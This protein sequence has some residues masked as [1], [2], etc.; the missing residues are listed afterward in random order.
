MALQDLTP[1]LRTRLS[2]MERA[3]GWFVILA[4]AVLSFGFVYYVYATAERK[5][6]F[7]LKAPYYT[8][9]ERAT[10]LKV[11]DP[12]ELMG[13]D[14]G[15]ITRIDAQKPWD[16]NNVYVEFEI[17]QPYYGYLWS[18][19]SRTKVNTAD[20]LGKRVL[21]V[22]KGTGGYSTYTFHP[23]REVSLAEA[24]DYA[25]SPNWRLAQE[26]LENRT[27]I[28]ARPRWPLTNLAAFTAA[29]YS[30]LT[31]MN[32]NETRKALAGI[33]NPWRGR[34]EIYTNGVSKYWLVADESAAVTERLEKLVGQIEAA[35]P[36]ILN[37]T[38]QLG[39]TLANGAN[40]T[41]NLNEVAVSLR[42]AVSNLAAATA[43]LDQPGALGVW[44]LP[45]NIHSNLEGVVSGANTNLAALAENLSR[46]L[47]NLAD[48]TSNLN[49]QV[50]ANTNLL[51]T[52][53][54]TI[55]DADQFVQGLKRH[56]LLRSA[57]KPAKTNAA[58]TT[59]P[60]PL[61]SPK[62]EGNR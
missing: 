32:T 22:T 24:Q 27:N 57:F 7:K 62:E 50:E 1:Q 33:W 36:N 2:R 11:G 18:E 28:I 13:F 20:F 3:V 42:P 4:M 16:P 30:R 23:V 51:S 58:P 41:S 38:N 9:T 54:R 8:Y 35:L 45:T 43:H 48:I 21:E 59:A 55:V 10:G 31:L 12:V 56:W 40:L 49:R 25:S 60:E 17:R 5:G 26:L 6:W 14:V 19:G 37:L 15:Q 29:G 46:S 53:S 44:L 47:D 61:R 34:Y 39:A 52:L